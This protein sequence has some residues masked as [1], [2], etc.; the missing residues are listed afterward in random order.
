[1]IPNYGQRAYLNRLDEFFSRIFSIKGRDND[2]SDDILR[3]T[4]RK[5]KVHMRLNEGW[6]HTEMWGETIARWM[7]DEATMT[8]YST[9]SKT[10]NLAFHILSFYR[11]RM[12]EISLNGAK[13]HKEVIQ[14]L[15]I[16]QKTNLCRKS[17]PFL[18]LPFMRIK[19]PINLKSGKNTIKFLS[20]DG[21]QCPSEISALISEDTRCLSFAIQNIRLLPANMEKF[22]RLDYSVKLNL[23][24]GFD[25]KTDYLNIDLIEFHDPDLV[26]DITHLD[27]LPSDTYEEILAQDCLEHLTRCNVK[28]ALKEWNRVLKKGGILKIRV[29]NLIGLLESLKILEALKNRPLKSRQPYLEWIIQCTFGTQAYK[30]DYH[31]SGF[32]RELLKSYLSETGFE[33]ISFQSRDDEWVLDGKAKK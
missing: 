4:I 16:L 6:H 25:I 7:A 33:R 22:D 13:T 32:T 12:L 15:E 29:P 1:M 14:T 8:I 28:P 24:C 17:D 20:V 27:V 9:E 30:G 2:A 3:N 21:C 18:Q 10:F 11:P 23:G 31:L 26:A 5:S 19:I